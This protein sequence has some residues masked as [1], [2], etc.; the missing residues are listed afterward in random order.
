M[1]VLDWAMNVHKMV[2]FTPV[3]RRLFVM[4]RFPFE[5]PCKELMVQLWNS[6]EK[7][8]NKEKRMQ[9]LY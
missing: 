4:C 9:K 8:F 5:L 6:Q 1:L 3:D 2:K 7:S